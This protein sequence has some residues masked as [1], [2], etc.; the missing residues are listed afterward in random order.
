MMCNDNHGLERS[1][2]YEDR[3][4]LMQAMLSNR[5]R[6]LENDEGKHIVYRYEE[7]DYG[8]CDACYEYKTGGQISNTELASPDADG[9]RERTIS[10][11]SRWLELDTFL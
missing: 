1:L 3:K 6:Y 10:L 8:C 2:L 4:T 11:Y 7:Y 9:R 5:Q